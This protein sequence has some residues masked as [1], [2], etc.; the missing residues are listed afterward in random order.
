MKIMT[1][2]G[3][4]RIPDKII[5]VISGYAALNCFG[6]KAM[7]VRGFRDELILLLR[8]ENFHKG[9]KVKVSDNSVAIELHI[10]MGHGVNM[11]NTAKSIMDEV[12]YIVQRQTGIKVSRVDVYI[13][14]VVI[15]GK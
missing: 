14:T 15:S 11:R 10:A 5:A 7:T 9:V 3:F 6:V 12:S 8:G 2:K 1:D 13:D 4:I